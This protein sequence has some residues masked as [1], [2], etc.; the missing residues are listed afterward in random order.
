M[1]LITELR[2]QDI[3]FIAEAKGDGSKKDLFIEGVFMQGGIKNKNGRYYPMG[4]LEREVHRY[5]QDKINKNTAYGEL[6]HPNGPS[7]NLD[8]VC[9]MV[10]S[11][12]VE[13]NN[14]IGRA[15]VT[16]SLPMGKIVAGLIEEGANL[17][18]SSR[19]MGSL[20]L[21]REGVNEVQDDFW[22]ATAADVVADPSA[23][24]AYVRGVMENVDWVL[25]AA[26]GNWIAQ[27]QIEDTK[28]TFKKYTVEQINE[29]K[30]VAFAQF[31]EALTKGKK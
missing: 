31:L 21:N 15:K 10:K 6:G 1:K 2:Q 14:I 25:D 4:I 13:G 8:R 23:P 11:L 22:L 18:V 3:H 9:H 29:A 27:Q 16:E 28:K 12:K 24:E 7:I 30:F 5:N 17:G 20:K 26:T 19:G